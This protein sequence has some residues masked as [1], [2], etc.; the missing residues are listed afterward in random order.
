VALAALALVI[1]ACAPGPRT[2]AFT[3]PG[4]GD[5]LPVSLVDRTGLVTGL[6]P[7]PEQQELREGVEP[8]PVLPEVLVVS[9]AGHTCDGRVQMILERDGAAF[10]LLA[11]T[12]RAD[13]C[14]VIGAI[15]FRAIA[16]SFTTPISPEAVT[17]VRV[18]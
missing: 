15:A 8:H 4:P 17:Y 18:P 6:Q 5:S 11:R 16:V 1:V 7:A 13:D 2:I 10:R 14:A 9:W 3:I 12:D